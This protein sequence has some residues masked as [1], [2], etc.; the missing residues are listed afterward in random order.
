[1]QSHVPLL[2]VTKVRVLNVIKTSPQFVQSL[3]EGLLH[4]L[5][6]LS[7][8]KHKGFVPSS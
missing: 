2:A 8:G 5:Q 6:D 4:F 1:M 3:E 7:Q